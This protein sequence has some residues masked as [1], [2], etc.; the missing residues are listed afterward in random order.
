MI[1]KAVAEFKEAV[2]LAPELFSY[3]PDATARQI[4][5]ASPKRAVKQ[6][7]PPPADLEDERGRDLAAQ[8]RTKEAVEAFRKARQLA[9]IIY[10]YD[11]IEEAKQ[12]AA[13]ASLT[14]ADRHLVEV[15]GLVQANQSDQ[16]RQKL[17]EAKALDPSIAM[18]VKDFEDRKSA[19]LLVEEGK[20]EARE[21]DLQGAMAKFR[22]AMELNPDLEL[23]PEQLAWRHEAR[24]D[25]NEARRLALSDPNAAKI[26]LKRER[27]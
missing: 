21:H 10:A 23:D 11:P 25:L 24:A 19:R 15:L 17:E 18:T 4:A 5:S 6:A 9:P 16:A 26:A 3:A 7:V 14:K 22:K 12:A 1:D 13:N 2:N 8:G 20:K 27:A